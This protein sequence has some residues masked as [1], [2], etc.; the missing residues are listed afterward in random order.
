M[1]HIEDDS[2]EPQSFVEQLIRSPEFDPR[3][4]FGLGEATWGSTE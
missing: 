2:S 3:I 4:L 1:Q